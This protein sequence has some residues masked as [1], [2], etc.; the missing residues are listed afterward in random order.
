LGEEIDPCVEVAEGAAA[1]Q[2]VQIDFLSGVRQ[3]ALFVIVGGLAALVNI[4]TRIGFSLITSFEVA[5]VLA[6]PIALSV[7]FVLNRLF[8]FN[9]AAGHAPTQYTHFI[10]V[11]LIAMVQV[12]VVSVLLA[13]V[14]FPWA[15]FAWNADTVAHVIGVASPVFTSYVLHGNYTFGSSSHR[16]TA[17]DKAS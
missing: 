1:P 13:R 6:F 3:F 15:N 17:R 12:F 11:N 9:G 14:I 5:V 8:V 16:V 2:K 7:A 10:I 4:V